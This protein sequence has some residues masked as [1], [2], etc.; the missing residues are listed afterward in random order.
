VTFILLLCSL[1]IKIV[2]GFV[3]LDAPRMANFLKKK[4]H[5]PIELLAYINIGHSRLDH[6]LENFG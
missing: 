1:N 3:K 5:K 6:T 4:I 2:L